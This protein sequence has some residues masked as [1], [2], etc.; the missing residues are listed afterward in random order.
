MLDRKVFF[1]HVRDGPFPGRLSQ[2]QV[3][4]MNTLL[5][6]WGQ[7]G[8]GDDRHLAYILATDFHET[9]GRMQPVRETFARSDKEARRRIASR[10]YGK[11]E[12]RFGQVYYGRGDV[13]L[14]WGENYKRMG[15]VLGLPLYAK[16]DMAL[17]PKVSKRILIEG[18]IRGISNKGDF[19][20]KAL[21]DYFNE[22]TDDPVGAR[23]V[24]NGT[25]KA[26]LIAGYYWEFVQAI[27][28]A[29]KAA[30]GSAMVEDVPDATPAKAPPKTDS[31][32]WGAVLTGLG[33]AASSILPLL[34]KVRD[35]YALAA[36]GVIVAGVVLIVRGRFKIVRETGQ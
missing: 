6:L 28:E 2:S 23:R 20:G 5:D 13:Q 26:D 16:P 21:E 33:G 14:T 29:R 25:D 7:H 30:V 4:G 10:R 34:D 9:G 3:E 17:D 18:M 31:I 27:E 12:G 32:T 24:V 36:L 8:T 15:T 22:R 11:P 19:T 35:P 1:A